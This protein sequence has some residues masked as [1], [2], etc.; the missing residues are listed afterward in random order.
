MFVDMPPGTGDVPL[1]VF[2]SLPVD[3]IIVVTS[4]QDLQKMIVGK[5]EN[6]WND[7]YTGNRNCT[8]IW[9]I[10]NVQ[11]N[12]DKHYF[13]END[14]DTLPEEYHIEMTAKIPIDPSLA[15]ACDEGRIEDYETDCL[16]N[17]IEKV[18][19]YPYE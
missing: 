7:A 12:Y 14:I 15:K 18:F 9:H 19:K 2:Q 16:D 17:L 3:G 13:S 10:M 6:G 1:A 11:P 4:P 8:K 5:T